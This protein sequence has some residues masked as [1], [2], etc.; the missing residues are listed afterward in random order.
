MK[1]ESE[2]GRV[3]EVRLGKGCKLSVRISSF[4]FKVSIIP[5][6]LHLRDRVIVKPLLTKRP[7]QGR[8]QR[9]EK[10]FFEVSANK[11]IEERVETAVDTAQGECSPEDEKHLKV[12]R[13][14]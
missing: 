4:H 10:L 14:L 11:D 7:G 3:L 13:F 9:L 12:M 5:W 6:G 8:R 2:F 1:G